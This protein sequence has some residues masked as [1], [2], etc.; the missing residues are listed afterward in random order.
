MGFLEG[1]VV[2]N[3]PANGRDTGLILGQEDPL[4]KKMTKHSSI[5]A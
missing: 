2:K 5:L 4:D 3:L 1:S